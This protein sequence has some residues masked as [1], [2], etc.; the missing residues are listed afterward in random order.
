MRLTGK[1]NP[2]REEREER[3]ERLFLA[4]ASRP[5]EG[6]PEHV[7]S[8]SL[9]CSGTVQAS[10]VPGMLIRPIGFSM[11]RSL[12]FLCLCLSFLLTLEDLLALAGLFCLLRSYQPSLEVPVAGLPHVLQK[13][14]PYPG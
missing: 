8:G 1:S 3:E 12:I 11:P 4:F 2:A 5:V 9:L 14:P 10:S 7:A 6:S 13:G